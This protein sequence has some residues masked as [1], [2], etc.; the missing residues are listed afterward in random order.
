MQGRGGTG[1]SGAGGGAGQDGEGGLYV[2]QAQ[3]AQ[4]DPAEVGDEM[5]VDVLVVATQ[6]GGPGWRRVASQCRSHCPVL[7]STRCGSVGCGG[8]NP[9]R[10][11]WASARVR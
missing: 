9:V 1:S 3:L 4:C 10:A 11:R 5:L 6:R 2:I 7:S 8:R